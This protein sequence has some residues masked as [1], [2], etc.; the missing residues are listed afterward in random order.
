MPV[1]TVWPLS[2]QLVIAAWLQ[3]VLLNRTLTFNFPS[4]VAD[5]LPVLVP[6][7]D[8]PSPP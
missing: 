2:D 5:R 6:L 4:C 1:P 3:L 7:L 8:Q